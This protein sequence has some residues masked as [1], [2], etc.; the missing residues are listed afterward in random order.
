MV[1]LTTKM[2]FGRSH[3]PAGNYWGDFIPRKE[4]ILYR[5]NFVFQESEARK[6]G[7]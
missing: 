7:T 6:G 2:G 5:K 1:H 3:Q 4:A